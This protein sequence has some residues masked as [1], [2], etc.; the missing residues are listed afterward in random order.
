VGVRVS[1]TAKG[2]C[3][4]HTRDRS[5]V[6]RTLALG[7]HLPSHLQPIAVHQVLVGC[8]DCENDGVWVGREFVA[9]GSNLFLHILWLVASGHLGDT[10]QIHQS[11][12]Q[13]LW[14]AV[15]ERRRLVSVR[16]EKRKRFVMNRLRER[17]IERRAEREGGTYMRRKDLQVDAL[18]G[19]ALVLAAHALRLPL[20]LGTD[21]FE[22]EEA[23]AWKVQELSPLL[24]IGSAIGRA[25]AGASL[26]ATVT[27]GGARSVGCHVLC[28]GASTCCIYTAFRGSHR[29]CCC[30]C[31]C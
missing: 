22:V 27:A 23:L 3:N 28:I 13:Y 25:G 21:L 6:T 1:G 20:D 10:R 17:H 29:R 12:V 4:R 15:V 5:H 7:V 30:C 31:C 2:T 11:K 24:A 19:D 26:F 18:V 9:H 8:S 14:V 16:G